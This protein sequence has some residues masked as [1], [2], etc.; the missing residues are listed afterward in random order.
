M[1][2]FCNLILYVAEP[3]GLASDFASDLTQELSEPHEPSFRELVRHCVTAIKQISANQP[4]RLT[5]SGITIDTGRASLPYV[6][7]FS[8]DQSQRLRRTVVASSAS[9][10]A[11]IVV[12]EHVSAIYDPFSSLQAFVEAA[13]ACEVIACQLGTSF[14]RPLMEALNGAAAALGNLT[15]ALTR[16]AFAELS[17]SPA[18]SPDASE[19][20]PNHGVYP[21]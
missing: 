15:Q 3:N 6:I 16:P 4:G 18:S 5:L 14:S 10:A 8:D 20:Y 1:R 2:A 7:I 9:S 12:I 21:Q 19:L 13:E 17:A 11:M